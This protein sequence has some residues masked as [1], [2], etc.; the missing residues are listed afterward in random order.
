MATR[1]GRPPKVKPPEPPTIPTVP[2]PERHFT[3]RAQHLIRMG[4]WLER[5]ENLIRLISYDLSNT[6][7]AWIEDPED[8]SCH[9]QGL[10]T[11]VEALNDLQLELR[12]L[13]EDRSTLKADG[14]LSILHRH[15]C[16]S[17]RETVL[18][19]PYQDGID[20][21]TDDD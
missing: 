5:N 19:P 4:E 3:F 18:I 10:Q 12:R 15:A 16:L 9:M 20:P 8:G 6:F 13:K 14:S 11:S 21:G 1:R 2:R 17:H 7:S